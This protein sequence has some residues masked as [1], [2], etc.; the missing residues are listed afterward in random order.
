M[1]KASTPSGRW[2]GV[3]AVSAHPQRCVLEDVARVESDCAPSDVDT[4]SLQATT[5]L[6]ENDL[7]EA[8][9]I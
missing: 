6:H 2:E 8:I 4:S 1:K 5:N 3:Q 9:H 7:N